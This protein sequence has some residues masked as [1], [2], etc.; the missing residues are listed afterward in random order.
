M[1]LTALTNLYLCRIDFS[2]PHTITLKEWKNLTTSS[3]PARMEISSNHLSLGKN[4]VDQS[5]HFFSKIL[6]EERFS[7]RMSSNQ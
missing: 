3:D 6:Q 7:N 4:Y 5:C 1:L 2:D